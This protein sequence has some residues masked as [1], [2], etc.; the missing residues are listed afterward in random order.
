MNVISKSLSIHGFIVS[1]LEPKYD[2]EFYAVVPAKVASGEIQHR[3]DVYDGLDKVGD[4]LLAV[5]QGFNKA[6]AVVHV[7]DN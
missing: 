3:E 1:R 5:Q 6:K 7:A 4:V 2:D